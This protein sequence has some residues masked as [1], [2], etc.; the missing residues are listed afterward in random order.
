MN[1]KNIN[2]LFDIDIELIEN[3]NSWDVKRI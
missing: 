1:S 3:S 2:Q